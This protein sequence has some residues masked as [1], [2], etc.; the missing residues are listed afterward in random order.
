MGAIN[1]ITAWVAILTGL[2]T[3]TAIGLFSHDEVWLGGY[4]SGRRRLAL[5]FSESPYA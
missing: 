2:V 4:G 1:L 5:W 3:G